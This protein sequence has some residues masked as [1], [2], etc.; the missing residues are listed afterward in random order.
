MTEK[1]LS[2]FGHMSEKQVIT[3]TASFNTTMGK[4]TEM[5]QRKMLLQRPM[6]L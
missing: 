5:S 6:M 4:M 1:E 2:Q 3:A